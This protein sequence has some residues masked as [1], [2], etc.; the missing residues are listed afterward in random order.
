MKKMVMLFLGLVLALSVAG[1][2]VAADPPTP[3]KKQTLCPVMAGKINPNLYTDYK[4][5]RIYFCCPVCLELF[6]KDPE[7]YLKKLGE[8]G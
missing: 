2:G 7:K 6:K 1:A 4:E 5:Q 3:A 8:Q